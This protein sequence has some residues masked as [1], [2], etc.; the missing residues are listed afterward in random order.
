MGS[1]FKNFTAGSVLTEADLDD[2]LMRQTVMTF[3]SSSARDTALSGVLDEGMVAYLE[4]DDAITVYTGSA[5]KTK[6]SKW[7]E[8]STPSYVELTIGNGSTNIW[9]KYQDY[10]LRVKGSITWGSTTS[11][12][13]A[14]GINIPDSNTSGAFSTSYGTATFSDATG[15]DTVGVVRNLASSSTIRFLTAGVASVTASAPFTWTTDDLVVFDI[16]VALY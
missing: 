3:A 1:G 2:Y 9:W 16:T 8:L 13:G 5:W 11:A 14:W 12:S 4:D 7:Q 6:V 10:D 15:S